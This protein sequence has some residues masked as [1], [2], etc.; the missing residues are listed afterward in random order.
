MNNLVDFKQQR[1]HYETQTAP[2]QRREPINEDTLTR[3]EIAATESRQRLEQAVD[4]HGNLRP[5]MVQLIDDFTTTFLEFAHLGDVAKYFADSGRSQVLIERYKRPLKPLEYYFTDSQLQAF[6]AERTHKEL[7]SEYPSKAD[8]L[9]HVH[10]DEFLSLMEQKFGKNEAR[11]RQ[12]AHAEFI[13]E[14]LDDNL[15]IRPLRNIQQLLEDSPLDNTSIEAPLEDTIAK[16]QAD[17]SLTPAQTHTL[18]KA[19]DSTGVVPGP[20]YSETFERI[21]LH[22]LD[23][24]ILQMTPAPSV[25]GPLPYYERL[26]LEGKTPNKRSR[27]LSGASAAK[28]MDKASKTEVDNLP[29]IYP[30]TMRQGYLGNGIFVNPVAHVQSISEQRQAIEEA[31]EIKAK[32]RSWTSNEAVLLNKFIDYTNDWMAANKMISSSGRSKPTS[33]ID[34]AERKLSDPELQSTFSNIISR[35]PPTSVGPTLSAPSNALRAIAQQFLVGSLSSSSSSSAAS[36]SVVDQFVQNLLNEPVPSEDIASQSPESLFEA[37]Q[38][39][40]PSS[41]GSLGSTS[42]KHKHPDFY[43][44][45]PE[46][47]HKLASQITDSIHKSQPFHAPSSSISGVSTYDFDIIRHGEERTD[48]YAIE[49]TRQSEEAHPQDAASFVVRSPVKRLALAEI[50]PHL[51]LCW[52]LMRSV[53]NMSVPQLIK[54]A[55]QGSPTPLQLEDIWE[56]RKLAKMIS[57]TTTELYNEASIEAS[58]ISKVTPKVAADYGHLHWFIATSLDIMSGA[59]TH[60]TEPAKPRGPPPPPPLHKH[61]LYDHLYDMDGLLVEERKKEI[62]EAITRQ[63]KEEASTAT[64]S[65]ID[66]FMQ[67]VSEKLEPSGHSP[68]TDAPVKRRLAK[69]DPA[70]VELLQSLNG[71]ELRSILPLDIIFYHPFLTLEQRAKALIPVIMADESLSKKFSATESLIQP[72]IPVSSAQ[73]AARSKYLQSELPQQILK[74]LRSKSLH[75]ETRGELSP[76][77]SEVERISQI[78]DLPPLGISL[79]SK[80]LETALKI[81]AESS[82]ANESEKSEISSNFLPTLSHPAISKL[83]TKT[84]LPKTQGEMMLDDPKISAK[85]ESLIENGMPAELNPDSIAYRTLAADLSTYKSAKRARKA[86]KTAEKREDFNKERRP[87]LLEKLKSRL[88]PL[89][90]LVRPEARA[91]IEP[92]E[93]DSYDALVLKQH[94]IAQLEDYHKSFSLVDSELIGTQPNQDG[95]IVMID[96]SGNKT[97]KTRNEVFHTRQKEAREWLNEVVDGG[98]KM[99]DEELKE[100]LS[101]MDDEKFKEDLAKVDDEELREYLSKLKDEEDLAELAPNSEP[102]EEKNPEPYI[103]YEEPH[104][105]LFDLHGIEASLSPAELIAK[106]RLLQRELDTMSDIL[107][108]NR[109]PMGEM[110]LDR[111]KELMKN[112]ISEVSGMDILEIWEKYPELAPAVPAQA[113]HGPLREI[114]DPLTP[115]RRCI[116]KAARHMYEPMKRGVASWYLDRDPET[117]APRQTLPLDATSDMSIRLGI[118]GQVEI[119]EILKAYLVNLTD[120]LH[121]VRLF[122]DAAKFAPRLFRKLDI[123]RD[124]D[125]IEA[126]EEVSDILRLHE[127]PEERIAWFKQFQLQVANYA[128]TVRTL[129]GPSGENYLKY[130]DTIIERWLEHRRF[131]STGDVSPYEINNLAKAILISGDLDNPEER[132]ALYTINIIL[133]QSLDATEL[134]HLKQV[135]NVVQ[136]EQWHLWKIRRK[137]RHDHQQLYKAPE[138]RAE[139]KEKIHNMHL[140]EDHPDV[141]VDADYY[142]VEE[143]A[144]MRKNLAERLHFKKMEEAEPNWNMI[145]MNNDSQVSRLN[146]LDQAGLMAQESAEKLREMIEN[147]KD[148]EAQLAKDEE[149]F[150]EIRA[151]FGLSVEKDVRLSDINQILTVRSA[152]YIIDNNLSVTE[153]SNWMSA[154]IETLKS[155]N[156]PRLI[157][158]D[159]LFKAIKYEALAPQNDL[160]A[161]KPLSAMSIHRQAHAIAET[162]AQAYRIESFLTKNDWS[163]DLPIEVLKRLADLK[164]AEENVDH[165]TTLQPEFVVLPENLTFDQARI[166]V[167]LGLQFPHELMFTDELIMSLARKAISE[168]PTLLQRALESQKAPVSLQELMSQVAEKMDSKDFTDQDMF[169]DILAI[170]VRKLYPTVDFDTVHAAP[171]TLPSAVPFA[172]DEQI[173]TS[174]RVSSQGASKEAPKIDIPIQNEPTP[175]ALFVPTGNPLIDIPNS[176]THAIETLKAEIEDDTSGTA[177]PGEIERWNVAFKL[178]AHAAILEHVLKTQG[179]SEAAQGLDTHSSLAFDSTDLK[180][181]ES[182]FYRL[183]YP[184]LEKGAPEAVANIPVTRVIPWVSIQNAL[185]YSD[186]QLKT[187]ILFL[188]NKAHYLSDMKALPPKMAGFFWEKNEFHAI[189]NHFL[190]VP[191][192]PSGIPTRE[193]RLFNLL[194]TEPPA[195]VLAAIAKKSQ[196]AHDSLAIQRSSFVRSEDFTYEFEAIKNHL[197]TLDD[198]VGKEA[199]ESAQ[200]AAS[201]M[202]RLAFAQQEA[203]KWP[204]DSTRKYSA[205]QA[206]LLAQG[207]DPS[208]LAVPK[209]LE[210]LENLIPLPSD[211]SSMDIEELLLR[212]QKIAALYAP[213]EEKM[214]SA[215]VKPPMPADGITSARFLPYGSNE[216]FEVE[217]NVPKFDEEAAEKQLKAYQEGEVVE[218]EAEAEDGVKEAGEE[219][220]EELKEGTGKEEEKEAAKEGEKEGE[221]EGAKEGEEEAEEAEEAAEDDEYD[222]PEIKKLNRGLLHRAMENRLKK[223]IGSVF[224]V[225][226]EDWKSAEDILVVDPYDPLEKINAKAMRKTFAG[227]YILEKLDEEH[228]IVQRRQLQQLIWTKWQLLNK[229]MRLL[230]IKESF[231]GAYLATDILQHSWS[232]SLEA[233]FWSYA[234]HKIEHQTMLAKA[235][236]DAWAASEKFSRRLFVEMM[237]MIYREEPFFIPKD[238]IGEREIGQLFSEAVFTPSQQGGA[239]SSID[240]KIYMP[241]NHMRLLVDPEEKN[242]WAKKREEFE[243]EMDRRSIAGNPKKMSIL[244]LLLATAFIAGTGSVLYDFIH[245]DEDSL[246]QRW[247]IE[248]DIMVTR[249]V[250]ALDRVGAAAIYLAELS[251]TAVSKL[252]WLFQSTV[253]EDDYRLAASFA[254]F[255]PLP[256]RQLPGYMVTPETG[257]YHYHSWLNAGMTEKLAGEQAMIAQALYIYENRNRDPQLQRQLKEKKAQLDDAIRHAELRQ[258]EKQKRDFALAERK[259][260]KLPD[261][262]EWFE[263]PENRFWD[264]PTEYRWIPPHADNFWRRANWAY[265]PD[266]KAPKSR[267]ITPDEILWQPNAK[268]TTEGRVQKLP[269]QPWRE[270]SIPDKLPP[271]S[272]DTLFKVRDSL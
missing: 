144:S 40:L 55:I 166:I 204:L 150:R 19:L 24:I 7:L 233:T 236:L 217:E 36:S 211:S 152:Q 61:P 96:A 119:E 261:M 182:E 232:N 269:F 83:F 164:F 17:R 136:F 194:F 41:S 189:R 58:E 80:E 65:T 56:A 88:D 257:G 141:R 128:D 129:I 94:L 127:T 108:A 107:G 38:S 16:L 69:M 105:V 177:S 154:R 116:P 253:N 224:T 265:H 11:Q 205:A 75:T 126:V 130:N 98:D 246:P 73:S 87:L 106:R 110:S 264:A 197:P 138:T 235:Y 64:R 186:R 10:S 9:E 207:L 174:I 162:P 99:S 252:L 27:G 251:A 82:E 111:V 238:S 168:R 47:S 4:R 254:H 43:H 132:A 193:E 109:V 176:F 245:Q 191:M 268:I 256:P 242:I 18:A 202:D 260:P 173:D 188:A 228:L 76:F 89:M 175:P 149:R 158:E 66:T 67:R 1:R 103:G 133:K 35:T 90:G 192:H 51:K 181:I 262:P 249:T 3:R 215:E 23:E 84:A 163:Q 212:S 113:V 117:S 218:V 213:S 124:F 216:R 199:R 178:F 21:L 169:S 167:F 71:A 121:Q 161:P 122:H 240:G 180:R 70:V 118:S 60:T 270:R 44:Y 171:S 209:G 137:L 157:S 123:S 263:M 170:D 267:M 248:A 15:V 125:S 179:A 153:M 31:T 214:K 49:S 185:G 45:T 26:R 239:I 52:A 48:K 272:S 140:P 77:G 201:K 230:D 160:V 172:N 190:G 198:N 183:L 30:F 134:E 151:G 62:I 146:T 250:A 120:P 147:R 237:P 220:T 200:I 139:R 8:L 222:G 104:S 165:Y 184:I 244:A 102:L 93:G 210:G 231:P 97:V 195:Q 78:L 37:S 42:H 33:G 148:E 112:W 63:K 20:T 57:D 95:D 6:I 34:W 203:S 53:A 143:D 74:H 28:E 159:P 25:N 241:D 2:Q 22:E 266:D 39:L 100:Y 54:L 187:L 227:D 101:K 32:V 135:E 79:S 219:A 68:D 13:E 5:Q 131:S 225:K 145:Y 156:W 86:K 155:E 226:D 223:D 92:L 12:A 91:L 221:K 29:N 81:A 46:S 258:Y 114:F 259:Q 229:Q 208:L 234:P 142:D 196:L 14:R 59:S 247:K 271:G 85:M 72:F 206:S 50:T 255:T 243:S 115:N